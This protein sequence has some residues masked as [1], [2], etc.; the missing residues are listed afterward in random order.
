MISL[1]NSAVYDLHQIF[2]MHSPRAR[3]ILQSFKLNYKWHDQRWDQRIWEAGSNAL[4]LDRQ[5]PSARIEQVVV[6]ASTRYTTKLFHLRNDEFQLLGVTS[7]P[8]TL[9]RSSIHRRETWLESQL[10]STRNPTTDAHLSRR[11]PRC[12]LQ[13]TLTSRPTRRCSETHLRFRPGREVM[14]SSANHTLWISRHIT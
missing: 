10:R 11:S 2:H 13:S 14:I 9:A 8:S 6:K 4:R 5:F 1:P 3:T 7:H 12:P